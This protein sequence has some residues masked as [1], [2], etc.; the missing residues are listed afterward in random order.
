MFTIGGIV[1]IG[2]LVFFL[3]LISRECSDSHGAGENCQVFST[4][5]FQTTR[6]NWCV[7]FLPRRR[8]L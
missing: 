8:G 2:L 7:G 5:Y 6:S 3:S 4:F 1:S